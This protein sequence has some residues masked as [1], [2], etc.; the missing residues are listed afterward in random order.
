M[1][2]T[3]SEPVVLR[4]DLPRA[5]GAVAQVTVGDLRAGTW[6]RLG[7]STVLGDSATEAT[8]AALADRTRAAGMAQGYAAGWAE[9]RK[10]AQEAAD[11]AAAERAA[12]DEQARARLRADQQALVASLAD[13]VARCD[14]VLAERQ[15]L[16]ATEAVDLGLRIAEA[17]LGRELAAMTDPGAEALRRALAEVPPTVAATVRLHPADAAALDPAET[18]GRPVTVVAD[19]AVAT[20]GAVLET[21]VSTVDA[22]LETAFARVRGALGR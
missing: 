1:T 16:L 13:V 5:P 11:E 3:S 17:V 4:G 10:R 18:A 21:E 6:T 19:P 22:S 9:G 20:G 7:A 8:L 15:E 12:A 2:S 14:A